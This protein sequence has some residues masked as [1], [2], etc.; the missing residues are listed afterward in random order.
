MSKGHNVSNLLSN[1]A[2]KYMYMCLYIS[3]CV[4]AHVHVCDERERDKT[5]GTKYELRSKGIQDSFLQV[6]YKFEMKTK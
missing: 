6:L 5:N 1:S 2:K 4:Y 3:T